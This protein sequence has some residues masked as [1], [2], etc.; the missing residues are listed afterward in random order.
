M[1]AFASAE[2]IFSFGKQTSPPIYSASPDE[3]LQ[4]LSETKSGGQDRIRT[5]EG[6]RP[7][8]LQSAPFDRFG[9][10]PSMEP[11]TGIEPVTF[12]LPW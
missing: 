4:A 10:C 11:L 8:D 6:A 5:Y 2:Y 3:T 7:A 1:S 9:T 12:T